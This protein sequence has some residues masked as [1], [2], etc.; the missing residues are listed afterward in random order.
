MTL[1]SLLREPLVHFL[2]F[3]AA[4]FLLD[5]RLR[6]V[7]APGASMDIV[8]SEA[9]VRNLA[10][11]FRRTWQRPP[12]QSE[13]DGLVQDFVRE[14]VFYR[15]ALALG[16]DKDD[17]I[18]RRRL[19]Q[20]MEF[21]AD[22][23]AALAKPTDQQLADYL[24]ANA[25][26]FRVESRAT[27]TQTFVDPNR[28]GGD[29][30]RLLEP[31]YDNVSQSEVARLFGAGFATALFDQ[32]SVPWSGSIQSGYGMHLVRIDAMTPGG[33]AT[34]E[35]VRPL[36]EREWAND[37]RKEASDAFYTGLRDKYKVTIKG[38]P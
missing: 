27:F 14:E 32:R 37:R 1:R 26:K 11:N 33:V 28:R 38:Q 18:I 6:P 10:Q 8:V 29:S 17:T 16:L 25:D 4:L 3:G 5:A 23:A 36:V 35:D 19:R 34:L 2:L 30:L 15:E 12:T 31:R 7:A 24:A 13:L 22:E 9:R 20:K 21:I